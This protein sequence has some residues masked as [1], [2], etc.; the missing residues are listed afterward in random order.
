ML[1]RRPGPGLCLCGLVSGPG[2]K[3]HCDYRGGWY[4]II[5]WLIVSFNRS[6]N[7]VLRLPLYSKLSYMGVE[8]AIPFQHLRV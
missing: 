3:E 8:P 1:G 7:R 6:V 4:L 5:L 2:E